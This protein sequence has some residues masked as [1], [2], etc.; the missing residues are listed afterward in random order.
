MRLM[1]RL[2]VC[3][4]TIALVI[5]GA[6]ELPKEKSP[7]TQG[8]PFLV[9][10]IGN[11]VPKGGDPLPRELPKDAA[12][13]VAMWD[14][15]QAA[16]T[17]SPRLKQLQHL[18]ELKPFDDGANPA[19][20]ADLA[21]EIRAN[22]QILAVI[23]HTTSPATRA[24][25]H[26]YAEAGIPL[27]MPIATS[28]YA[29]LPPGT[30][31]QNKRLRNVFRLA[32]SDDRVQG[33][34][35]AIVAQRLGKHCYLLADTSSPVVSE[36][37]APLFR[38]LHS[39]LDQLGMPTREMTMQGNNPNVLSLASIIHTA[40]PEVIIF[41]GYGSTAAELL[42]ALRKEY[43]DIDAKDRP[44][45]LLSDG[46][47]INTL[48]TTGFQ[49]FLT[50]PLPSL[51]PP[52][53]PASSKTKAT[54][55]PSPQ[56]DIDFLKEVIIRNGSDSYQM[57]AY[58]ALLMIGDAVGACS[59]VGTISRDCV[60]DKLNALNQFHGA[61]LDYAF[62]GG[63][64]ELAEYYVYSNTKDQKQLLFD[65]AISSKEIRKESASATPSP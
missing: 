9:A 11:G 8:K 3:S 38:Y 45:I 59:T 1:L 49:V 60:R 39:R 63:E 16:L 51:I 18:A 15:A 41:C 12:S 50:F 27:L 58:D 56:S 34:A 24:A 46:C 22:P 35:M 54:P 28:P 57:Y 25:A 31:D 65:Y 7:Q 33:P 14:G 29:V 36:Y 42:D 62:K 17:S 44:K 26:I 37:T 40:R 48:D 21:R 47:K 52:K 64:N 10:V 55:M 4:L 61:L 20:A 13:G 23:G 19:I 53:E 43:K 30:E 2:S 5:V 32:P 6:C